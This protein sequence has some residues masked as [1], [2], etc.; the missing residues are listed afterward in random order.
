M[1]MNAGNHYAHPN[2]T[3]SRPFRENPRFFVSR[4]PVLPLTPCRPC[5]LSVLC[6]VERVVAY[7]S[8]P[9]EAPPI[10]PNHRPP[11]G[12]VRPSIQATSFPGIDS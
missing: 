5:S 6:V 2:P 1:A 9:Q 3:S 4:A 7:M 11:P 10:V 8:I 12:Y